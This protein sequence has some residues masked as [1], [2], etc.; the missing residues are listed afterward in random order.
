MKRNLNLIT[1]TALLLA[2]SSLNAETSTAPTAAQD[3]RSTTSVATQKNI[4]AQV[5]RDASGRPV[6]TLDGVPSNFMGGRP[7]SA[8]LEDDA[9]PSPYHK[10]GLEFLKLRIN[11]GVYSAK[12][13]NSRDLQNMSP[14]WNGKRKYDP[15][16][17]ERFLSNETKANPNARLILY[18]LIRNYPE[19]GF[20][21]P[22]QDLSL[23]DKG[24]LQV[25]PGARPADDVIRNEKGES[26]I[27]AGSHFERFDTAAPQPEPGAPNEYAISFFSQRYRAEVTAMLAELVRT[28]EASPYADRVA[29]YMLGGGLDNQQY[30]WSVP[31]NYLRNDPHLWGDYSPVAKKAFIGWMRK[32][33]GENLATVNQ[34][35]RTKF[36]SFD[37]ITPPPSANLA[38]GAPFHD[39]VKERWAYDFKRFLAEG[40]A[41]FIETLAAAIKNAAT[42]KVLVGCSAADGAA[43]RDNT[44]TSRLIR[45]PHID[46]S[47]HQV[48]YSVR[49]PPSAGGF[50]ALLDTY[51]VNG[52]LFVA[53]MDHRLWTG[54][55]QGTTKVGSIVSYTDESVGRA[56]D[57]PMQRA[58]WRRELARLWISGNNGT[59]FTDNDFDFSH[60]DNAEIRGELALLNQFTRD[61]VRKRT[62]AASVPKA[63]PAADVAFIF[64]E[65]AVDFARSAL[66]EFHS[67]GLTA[68]WRESHASGVPIRYYYA[69]DLREA[70]IPPAKLYVLQNLI[71]I[72]ESMAAQ[73][74]KLREAGATIVV[75]QGT[76]MAQLRAGTADFLDEVLGI[77]LRPLDTIAKAAGPPAPAQIASSHPLLVGERWNP[78]APSFNADRLKEV[79]GIALTVADSRASILGYYPQS[80]MPA[81]A[82]VEGS[83]GGKVVFVGAYNLSRDAISRLAAY[84]GAWRVAPPGNVIAAGGELLMIHP[85]KDGNVE[86][87]PQT[88]AALRQVP[89]GDVA[90]P[91]AAKHT[92]QLKAGTTYLFEVTH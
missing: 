41:D 90:S 11:A 89:P 17:L 34:A 81:S 66:S 43:R 18:L 5:G 54:P 35:W 51:P 6:L 48:T 23:S 59:L 55:I 76:G 4:G 3:Q 88:A 10:A 38:G 33:Y 87:V 7:R 37:Q 74:K 2:A 30:A 86:V 14:F 79:E 53:D 63:P 21:N 24:A 47:F 20:A 78:A 52:K 80:G 64:D 82:V 31:D 39:P 19:F 32:K 56:A 13:L 1:L 69:Q 62:T 8:S 75:L 46:Y 44:T 16:A 71:N 15:K 27:I 92:L 40:R 42:R 26:M 45:S 91:K 61:L 85:L 65:E 36:A 83:N 28:V 73:I 67:A 49:I 70:L 50:N 68:Q 57:M 9:R 22:E 58:M 60:W 72:D 29:G 84:A 25:R 12:T 77:K